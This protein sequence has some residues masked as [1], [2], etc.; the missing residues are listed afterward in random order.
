MRHCNVHAE[1]LAIA[2]ALPL[3]KSTWLSARTGP[4]F[5][6]S[7]KRY[8]AELRSDCLLLFPAKR[9]LGSYKAIRPTESITQHS[10]EESL[11]RDQV[12]AIAA[13]LLTPGV[14]LFSLRAARLT[15]RRDTARV[16]IKCR[17]SWLPLVITLR[18]VQQAADWLADFTNAQNAL[19]KTLSD[20]NVIR[21]IGEGAEGTVYLAEDTHRKEH[22]AVKVIDK[23]NRHALEERHI[24]EMTRSHP[25]ILDMRYAFQNA[26]RVF[27]I[28]EFCAGGDLFQVMKRGCT[29]VDED[30]IRVVAA[31]I[32]L[33]LEHIHSLGVVYRDLKLEN[34]LID[35]S[36][37]VRVADFGVSK[38][39]RECNGELRRTGSFCG[40]REYIA[41][42]ML[43]GLQYNTSIDVWAFGILLYELLS[44]HTPFCCKETE[45]IYRRIEGAPIFYP[46]NLSPQ[47][48]DLLSGLLRRDATDR[49]GAGED[50]WKAVREHPWFGTVDWIA[51]NDKSKSGSP[52]KR[53]VEEMRSE[54]ELPGR[55]N[56]HRLLSSCLQMWEDFRNVA[57]H[58]KT[59]GNGQSPSPHS[60]RLRKPLSKRRDGILVGYPLAGDT[61]VSETQ[62]SVTLSKE[63][64]VCSGAASESGGTAV[65]RK[66]EGEEVG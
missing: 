25:Y 42:E 53:H 7:P 5:L 3:A 30:T 47:V 59:N 46:R 66:I 21:K 51:L 8:W 19:D 28:T 32:L 62:H 24:L 40:T 20:F 58:S 22:L 60:E 23:S 6:T 63:L 50:G 57:S 29:P 38:R 15:M 36:G 2:H 45:E 56:R 1:S 44:G 11:S 26:K 54:G 34:I 65:G 4:R 48:Q 10:L 64:S 16:S 52:L 37:N 61:T 41:P 55:P 18:T 27:L 9:I 33:A 35:G 43:A 49:L 14:L 13:P 31:Q 17:T 39:L 12:S